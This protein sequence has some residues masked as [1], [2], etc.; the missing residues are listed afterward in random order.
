MPGSSLTF[1][2]FGKDV[3]A[4]SAMSEL[5]RHAA[6]TG[7]QIQSMSGALSG[8]GIGTVALG[9][10]AA[11]A[12]SGIAQAAQDA[13]RAVLGTVAANEQAAISFETLLGSAERASAFMTELKDFAK[14]TPFE[15]GPLTQYSKALLGA[16]LAAEHVVPFLTAWGDASGALG[17]T[18]EQF[19]R[20]MTAVTQIMS[21]GKV[22]AEELG[23]IAE[24]GIPI[25]SVLSRALG[26]PAGELMKLGEQGK[27]VAKQVLPALEAQ[28]RKD[29]GG[30][31]GKQ[32]Q[33]LNGL[34][35]TLMDTLK[36]GTADALLPVQDEL[37]GG[38]TRSIEV[39]GRVTGWLADTGVPAFARYGQALRDHLV[40][41]WRAASDFLHETALPALREVAEW[42]DEN[43]EKLKLGAAA[44]AGVVV[45]MQGLSL[46]SS[47]LAALAALANPIGIAVVAVGALAGGLTYLYQNS[48]PVRAFLD[49][50]GGRVMPV[51]QGAAEAVGDYWSNSLS[52]AL[53]DF[54]SAVLPPLVEAWESL[55]ENFGVGTPTFEAAGAA[56]KILGAFVSNLLLPWL[57]MLVV[58]GLGRLKAAFDVIGPVLNNVVV[59]ALKFLMQVGLQVFK[60]LLMAAADAFGWVPEIGDKLRNASDR[61]NAFADDVNRSLDAINSTKTITIAMTSTG[62]PSGSVYE[63]QVPGAARGSG[64]DSRYKPLAN[65]PLSGGS[66]QAKIWNYFK[67]QGFTDASSAGVI[68]NLI[69][70][71]ALNPKAIQKG[72]PGR[73]LAQW[74][75]GERWMQLQSW[76]T[77]GK[78]NP[79]DLGTQLDYLMRELGKAPGTAG[80][81]TGDLG[82]LK[83]MTSSADAAAYFM[84]TFERPKN[85][86][87]SARQRVAARVYAQ[88]KGKGGTTA[89]SGGSGGGGTGYEGI[90]DAA[91]SSKAS[92]D[93]ARKASEAARK[94]ALNALRKDLSDGLMAALTGTRAQVRARLYLL[95][96]D[97]TK[98]GSAVGRRI[99]S[100]TART[101]L[102]LASQHDAVI[103]RLEKAQADL[104]GL[105]DASRQFARQTWESTIESG[106]VTTS[107]DRSF[108]GIAEKLRQSVVA[109]RKFADAMAELKRRGLGVEA[110]KQLTAAGPEQGLA[111]AQGILAAGKKGIA[112]INRLQGQLGQA[113]SSLGNT[114]ADAMYAAGIR[115]AEGLVKGLQSQRKA[116]EAI[117]SGLAQAM[118]AALRKALGIKSPSVVFAGIGDQIGAGLIMGLDRQAAPVTSTA[119]GLISRAA[120]AGPAGGRGGPRFVPHQART[121][122]HIHLNRA[123]VGNEQHIARVLGVAQRRTA[124]RGVTIAAGAR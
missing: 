105:R 106:N 119:A 89:P 12:F 9:S 24:S 84:R 81:F 46:A 72:G 108:G 74:S 64:G 39:A 98:L 117:M 103:K 42:V 88:M 35:S 5:G 61:F 34:W 63:S 75:L 80:A 27:L 76:A 18:Q 102:P 30:A 99:V 45:A 78:R 60:G 95:M 37:K 29:Y 4:G 67:G 58:E 93:A 1:S 97:V 23:Q 8:A 91:S 109:A 115:S 120:F 40:G 69:A 123:L 49:D 65:T 14:S 50:L 44:I 7:R 111:Y 32:A 36:Q 52:P 51:L 43:S 94:A 70:E 92:S 55:V 26:K 86:D 118:A 124:G 116:L 2:L 38:L 53:A 77:K 71:S 62:D 15:T 47:G 122:T 82:K 54:G 22:S 33:T 21:K 57:K 87:P 3:S 113:G 19:G 6:A 96:E 101:L 83:G 85:T 79:W 90:A 13:G 10:I 48:E 114:T 17:Q 41:P 59:P 11:N 31:M 28:M 20:T 66:N 112:E 100:T 73:G 56:L 25:W 110:L 104:K 16:G 107:D 121:E 68:A